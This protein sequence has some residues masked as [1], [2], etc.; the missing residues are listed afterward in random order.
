MCCRTIL[1]IFIIVIIGRL[2][3]NSMIHYNVALYAMI[4]ANIAQVCGP[5]EIIVAWGIWKSHLPTGLL[6]L[7]VKST[8]YIYSTGATLLPLGGNIN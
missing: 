7:K 5:V 1:N 4:K 3:L 6:A 2:I 8:P